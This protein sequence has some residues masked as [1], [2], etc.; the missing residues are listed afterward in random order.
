MDIGDYK[1]KNSTAIQSRDTEEQ[2][3]GQVPEDC[4]LSATVYNEFVTRHMEGKSFKTDQ[5]L[6]GWLKNCQAHYSVFDVSRPPFRTPH[7]ALRIRMAGK[8]NK[9]RNL[10]IP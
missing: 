3:F 10:E 5:Q 1:H 4:P 2:Y 8:N 9:K 7:S 6:A